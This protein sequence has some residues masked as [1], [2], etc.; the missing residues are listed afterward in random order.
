M[1]PSTSGFGPYYGI[2]STP[3]SRT[4]LQCQEC[5]DPAQD[6]CKG[7]T[8]K[9]PPGSSC[10]QTLEVTR[11]GNATLHAFRRSCNDDPD[12]CNVHVSLVGGPQETH[13]MTE[14]CSSD[15]CNKC[16]SKVPA[17]NTTWNGLLCPV[18]FALDT[19]ECKSLGYIKCRGEQTECLDFAATLVKTDS[20]VLKLS[21]MGCI[22]ARGCEIIPKS[23]PAAKV[24]EANRFSCDQAKPVIQ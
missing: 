18:C 10:I 19:Y 15:N 17:Y 2:F 21:L 8:Q 16:K 22:T 6:N 24:V 9:C 11:L 3:G 4:S 23:L 1:L 12:I 14:C 5:T 20:T 13:I 7:I